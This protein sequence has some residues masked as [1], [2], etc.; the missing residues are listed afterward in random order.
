MGMAKHT[1]I[2]QAV[3]HI[4]ASHDEH[5]GTEGGLRRIVVFFSLLA[6]DNHV[7]A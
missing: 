4:C 7:K 5:I 3:F 6:A 1:T 2:G